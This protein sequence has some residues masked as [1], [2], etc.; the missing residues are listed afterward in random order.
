MLKCVNTN[1]ISILLYCY[2][3]LYLLSLYVKVHSQTRYCTDQ[4][5]HVY[6]VQGR[7][8]T[9]QPGKIQN[10]YTTLYGSTWGIHE[11]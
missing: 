11:V 9:T 2:L 10:T 1:N 4:T 5:E 7:A 6:A 8:L 3:L